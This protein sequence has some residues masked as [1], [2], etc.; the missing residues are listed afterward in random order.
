[1]NWTGPTDEAYFVDAAGWLYCVCQ[2]TG[3]GCAT[4]GGNCGNFPVQLEATSLSEPLPYN[5][6]I[7][8]VSSTGKVYAR[9][10]LYD[11]SCSANNCDGTAAAAEV[12]AV[13]GYGAAA[14]VFNL[15]ATVTSTVAIMNNGTQKVALG[16]DSGKVFFLP[17]VP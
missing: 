17:V 3:T 5:G 14:N 4:I 16:T 10:M 15:G 13:Q 9:E 7:Y 8:V 11:P 12:G 2:E 1:M 6:T